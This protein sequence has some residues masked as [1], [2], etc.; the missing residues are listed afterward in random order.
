MPVYLVPPLVHTTTGD[1]NKGPLITSR[2]WA[3]VQSQY[4]TSHG[5][6]NKPTAPCRY[7]K[8]RFD[9][10]ATAYLEGVRREYWPLSG[11]EAVLQSTE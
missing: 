3:E 5:P 9:N 6:P 10:H 4:F 11:L 8:V 1:P 2:P 7:G